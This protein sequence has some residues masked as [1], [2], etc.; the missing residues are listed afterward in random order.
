MTESDGVNQW[1]YYT[2]LLDYF[3]PDASL[4]L[5]MSSTAIFMCFLNDIL[6]L[7]RHEITVKAFPLNSLGIYLISSMFMFMFLFGNGS[8]DTE[9]DP[10]ERGVDYVTSLTEA[11]TI[12]LVGKIGY[13]IT[14]IW[15]CFYVYYYFHEN[16]YKAIGIIVCF[17]VSSFVVML[18]ISLILRIPI[19][20]RI[21]I[22]VIYTCF[23]LVPGI[24][25]K[26]II[27]THDKNLFNSINLFGTFIL[28]SSIGLSFI[29]S[30]NS[31][32]FE[33]MGL[34]AILNFIAVASLVV[35]YFYLCVKYKGN[36]NRNV[37]ATISGNHEDEG[38]AK[39][40]TLLSEQIEGKSN[41]QNLVSTN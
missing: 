37:E 20:N 17:I 23:N 5:I 34:I 14:M 8:T 31:F 30:M 12:C 2:D 24:E 33:F 35:F 40:D 25:I 3:I 26:R 41:M 16:R 36:N 38:D 11:S 29:R 10:E 39:M 21:I 13:F 18:V 7:T 6:K 27:E 22:A 19:L 15:G 28:S 1:G 9:S 32:G 4:F